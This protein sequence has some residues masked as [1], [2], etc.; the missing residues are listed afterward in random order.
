MLVRESA[1]VALG[2][3]SSTMVRVTSAGAMMSPLATPAD[4][5]TVSSVLSASC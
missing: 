2:L 3:S 1:R 5:V 4:T